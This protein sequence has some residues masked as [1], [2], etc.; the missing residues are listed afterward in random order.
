MMAG[1]DLGQVVLGSQEPRVLRFVREQGERG[2]EPEALAREIRAAVSPGVLDLAACADA[3]QL[4]VI[5]TRRDVDVPF[6]TQQRLWE[7]L[8]RPER[9]LLPTGHR[10]VAVYLPY[11]LR[12]VARFFERAL[13]PR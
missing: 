2:L 7:A 1:G 4:L 10:T 13:S 5:G 8:G 11:L 3:R 9:I 6:S 12:E